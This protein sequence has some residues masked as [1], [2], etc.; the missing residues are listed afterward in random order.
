MTQGFIT[1][2]L[3]LLLNDIEI[4]INNI[5]E[6]YKSNYFTVLGEL[7]TI[8]HMIEI[9]NIDDIS[10][11]LKFNKIFDLNKTLKGSK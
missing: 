10:L 7:R 1:N 8:E 5:D 11:E 2:K 9:L 6:Y 3:S 4:Q